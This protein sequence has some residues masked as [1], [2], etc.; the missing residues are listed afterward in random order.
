MN[1]TDNNINRSIGRSLAL[2]VADGNHENL[3]SSTSSFSKADDQASPNKSPA[4]FDSA[5]KKKSVFK[6]IPEYPCQTVKPFLENHSEFF[7]QLILSS[8][9]GHDIDL[10]C[11]RLTKHLN[12]CYKC[13]QIFCNTMREYYNSLQQLSDEKK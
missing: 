5:K 3:S 13:F 11:N 1:A 6:D 12:D 4:D 9:R 8:Q 10:D 2:L 7:L